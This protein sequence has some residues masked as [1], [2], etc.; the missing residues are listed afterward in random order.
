M[1][2]KI[3]IIIFIIIGVL[4]NCEKDSIIFSEPEVGVLDSVFPSLEDTLILEPLDEDLFI[5]MV[6]VLGMWELIY[7]HGINGELWDSVPED[8]T[9]LNLTPNTCYMETPTGGDTLVVDGIWVFQIKSFNGEYMT[10]NLKRG[11]G[12]S[13]LYIF[14]KL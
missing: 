11:D 3:T 10:L 9:H 5:P 2:V 8:I 12:W 7:Y 4:S 1:K 13:H 6:D 14:V